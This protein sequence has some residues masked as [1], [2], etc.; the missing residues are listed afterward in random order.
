MFIVYGI[1]YLS[2]VAPKNE[3]DISK[4]ISIFLIFILF[5]ISC[6]MKSYNYKPLITKGILGFSEIEL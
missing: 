2:S 5:T 1:S 6:L 3:N 4:V